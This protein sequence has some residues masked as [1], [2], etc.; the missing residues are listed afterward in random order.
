M[1]ALQANGYFV[2]TADTVRVSG[3]FNGWSTTSGN[4]T[5]GT[6][7]DSAIY[8]ASISGV[9][10]GTINYKFIFS[11]PVGIQWETLANNRQAT[12]GT[13]DVAPSNRHLFIPILLVPRSMY[14]SR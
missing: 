2:P 11:T 14:G 13:S 12:I 7:A 8:S 4:L 3:D 9:P 5:K 10:T 1:T 6:G